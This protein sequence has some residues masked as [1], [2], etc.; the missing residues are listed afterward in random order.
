MEKEIVMR[1]EETKEMLPAYVKGEGE[2]LSLRR[3]LA[4]CDDCSVELDRYSSL[5]ASLEAL[6][7]ARLETPAGLKASLMAIPTESMDRVAAVRTHVARN[8]S[9]YAGGVAVALV[10]AAGAALWASRGRRAAT[11]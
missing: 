6:A 3:H 11:A 7:E 4:T 2:T 9:K 8:R 5:T 1:C 10:G